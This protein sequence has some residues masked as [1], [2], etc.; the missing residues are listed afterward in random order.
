MNRA[1]A[2]AALVK[3]HGAGFVDAKWARR[4]PDLALIHGEP[5]FER[6]YPPPEGERSRS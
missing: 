2:M 3:S 6:L 5:E 4:E 1:E